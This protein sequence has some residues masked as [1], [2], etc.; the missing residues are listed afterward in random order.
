LRSTFAVDTDLRTPYTMNFHL[1][2]Q[3]ELPKSALLDIS[4]V[5]TQGRKL[6]SKVNTGELYGYLTDP[7]SGQSLW[8]AMNHIVDLIGPNVFSPA[9]D[10]RSATA[11]AAIRPIPFVENL[12]TNLPNHLATR[13]NNSLYRGLTPTQAF[14]S[15]IALNA[16]DY[17]TP[18]RTSFDVFPVGGSPWNASVDPQGDG[19]V[20]F[21]PQLPFE[22]T[23][24]NWGASNYHSLQI[25]LRRSVGSALFGVNYV[26]SKSIDNGSAAENGDVINPSDGGFGNMIPNAFMPGAHR[27]VSDFD[28]RHNFNAHGVFDLP[29]GH[30]RA[31][32]KSAS[33]ALEQLIGGWRLTGV[34]RWRSGLPLSPSLINNATSAGTSPATVI[35]ELKSDVTSVAP[36]GLPNLFSDPAAARS[37]T[38]FTR[39]GGA[40]S[41]NAFRGPAYFVVDLGL[42]KQFRLP[43][44]ERQR[45]EFRWQAFNAFNNVNFSTVGIELRATQASFGRITATAGP[46][47]G[48]R[49]MEFALR[50]T[51]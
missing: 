37:Q 40:G 6:L 8:G 21:Q 28:L 13:L 44:S 11:L 2:L 51:F 7:K 35:G 23:W 16:P 39:P 46:R 41:R 20:L 48:A 22:A 32:G 17:L 12:L 10:P 38:T 25:T 1:S 4:Y 29:F 47:G 45:L 3:R 49:E 27:A 36:D 9:I 33:G 15:Y 24:L 30:G 31:F 19:F 50:Y 5:G 43:W 18:L 34:W 42:H 26:L 14:Y